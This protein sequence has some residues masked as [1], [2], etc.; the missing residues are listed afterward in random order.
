M[1]PLQL[2]NVY[3]YG[4]KSLYKRFCT[5]RAVSETSL[6][7][8]SGCKIPNN[9]DMALLPALIW[10]V[11][12]GLGVSVWGHLSRLVAFFN[13][14]SYLE[15]SKS[16]D[17]RFHTGNETQRKGLLKSPACGAPFM[18]L[19]SNLVTNQIFFLIEMRRCM[20]VCSSSKGELF[21]SPHSRGM[22]RGCLG[23]DL[24][25]AAVSLVKSW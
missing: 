18:F 23:S 9:N 12:L 20:Y 7:E 5:Y 16:A 6:W 24:Y 17:C 8:W 15:A 4:F 3:S 11:D 10:R 13:F 14:Q 21:M 1:H 19:E 2:A 22:C 25:S